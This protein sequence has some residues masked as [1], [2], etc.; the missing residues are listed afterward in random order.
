M[1]LTGKEQQRV[2][3]SYTENT[4]AYQLYLKGRY[5]WSKRTEEG[6]NK[7]TEHIQ[8]AIDIDPNYALAYVG[9]ADCY[10][11]LGFYS[12]LEPK[13][14]FPRAKAAATK[15][16]EIDDTLAE[17]H[18]SLGYVKLFYDWDLTSAESELKQAIELNPNY[19]TAHHWY[20]VYLQLVG[21]FDQALV[22]MRRALELDPLSP[23]INANVGW[24]LYYAR[25]YDQAIEQFQKAVERDQSS[26]LP[27]HWLAMVYGQKGMYEEAITE[28]QKALELSGSRSRIV[29][30]LGY[31]YAVSGR[32]SEAQKALKE[33]K[34][35]SKR[36]HVSSFYMALIYMGLGEKDQAFASFETAYEE[37]SPRLIDLKVDPIF[38]PLRSDPRFAVLI[39]KMGLTP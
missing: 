29:A 30:E 23:S 9:L 22:E 31:I 38:D 24:P 33:L 27:H 13:E 3:K 18:A 36:R 25:Q 12:V 19:A 20:G 5:F 14:A 21:R 17:A 1:R 35:L 16:L 26:P 7:A 10:N 11:L 2:T 6:L 15:A 34:E 8:Q 28:Y 39:R 37:R 32:R 4:A